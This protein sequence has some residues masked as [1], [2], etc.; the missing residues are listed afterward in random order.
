MQHRYT[1]LGSLRTA[2]NNGIGI[3][4]RT[5]CNHGLLT[6]PESIDD[7]REMS[8]G[9]EHFVEFLELADAPEAAK[10]LTRA[11]ARKPYL[12]GGVCE[13]ALLI[14]SSRNLI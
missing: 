10:E 1:L 5:D 12:L 11:G 7:Q 14:C 9:H 2:F 3:S 8:E 6:Q 4:H 13:G